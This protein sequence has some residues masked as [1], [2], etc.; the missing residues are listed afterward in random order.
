MREDAKV[1]PGKADNYLAY[2]E[3]K[4]EN[5]DNGDSHPAISVWLDHLHHRA[6]AR[7]RAVYYCGWKWFRLLGSSKSP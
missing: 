1:V 5:P 3:D 6:S 7:Y 2:S 4:S